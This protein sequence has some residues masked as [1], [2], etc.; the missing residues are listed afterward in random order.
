MATTTTTSAT[1]AS[2]RE[3]NKEKVFDP[4]SSTNVSLSVGG[5]KCGIG[6][7]ASFSGDEFVYG[8]IR[9]S[10]DVDPNV[11]GEVFI[12]EWNVSRGSRLDNP[13]DC[14]AGCGVLRR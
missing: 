7:Q 14:R 12:L 8:R 9:S 11:F 10:A 5:S 1:S 4:S 6:D 2:S 13:A 3:K